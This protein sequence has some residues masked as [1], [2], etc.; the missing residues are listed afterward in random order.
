[1]GFE[2]TTSSMPSRRAPNCATA[3][4]E[5]LLIVML[6]SGRTIRLGWPS[7][8]CAYQAPS[9]SY[10]SARDARPKTRKNRKTL[11]LVAEQ[12]HRPFESVRWRPEGVPLE[13]SKQ[14]GQTNSPPRCREATPD[15]SAEPTRTVLHDPV[16]K[17]RRPGGA[18][19][20]KGIVESNRSNE[21]NGRWPGR[22]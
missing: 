5:K 21:M 16:P 7:L 1:M 4:P 12:G 3:P 9:G 22:G 6:A 14:D 20:D 10:R 13:E 15:R 19:P 18:S 2:P 17:R 11:T 8:A